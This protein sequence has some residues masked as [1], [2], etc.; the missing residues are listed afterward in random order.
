[1]LSPVVV[2]PRGVVESFA[3]DALELVALHELTHIARGDLRSSALVDLA[4]ILLGP[5]PTARR[6]ARDACLA[7][8]QAVD[9]RVAAQAPVAYARVLVD[10]AHHARFGEPV[11]R[12][13]C[14]HGSDLARRIGAMGD[15]RPRQR[16]SLAP[17]IVTTLAIVGSTVAAP[18]IE[19]GHCPAVRGHSP[20]S[21]SVDRPT[22]NP[23]S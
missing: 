3:P 22:R 17:L 5:H 9:A 13:V 11:A 18:R 12:A 7:R 14:M 8:E 16:A 20:C 21:A 10:V 15:E 19:I 4:C 1:V 23:K 6:L 2:L